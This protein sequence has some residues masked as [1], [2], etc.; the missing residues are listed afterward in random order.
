MGTTEVYTQP[1]RD[2]IYHR[3][4]AGFSQKQEIKDKVR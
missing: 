2:E 4:Q 3:E 1:Q